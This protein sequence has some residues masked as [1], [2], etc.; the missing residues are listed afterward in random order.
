MKKTVTHDYFKNASVGGELC[1]I[2]WCLTWILQARL[3]GRTKPLGHKR[4]F[5]QYE[6]LTGEQWFLTTRPDCVHTFFPQQEIQKVVGVGH[7]NFSLHLRPS[8]GRIDVARTTPL[9]DLPQLWEPTP[10]FS[11]RKEKNIVL[12]ELKITKYIKSIDNRIS[13]YK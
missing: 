8:E 12:E 11:G 10:H 5:L 6:L 7:S 13:K 1:H 3:S 2:T 4:G 9:L